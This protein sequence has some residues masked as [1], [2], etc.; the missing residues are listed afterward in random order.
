MGQPVPSLNSGAN[1]RIVTATGTAA[2]TGESNLVF[3]GTKLGIGQSSPATLL[4]VKG[5]ETAYSSNVA[6]GAILQLEDS[7]GRIAQFIAP[8]LSLIH[9]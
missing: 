9:I 3:D 2:M 5:N 8:G 4:N 7:V 1:N 6:V